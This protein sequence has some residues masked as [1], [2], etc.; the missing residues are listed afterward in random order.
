MNIANENWN[1]RRPAYREFEFD[2]TSIDSS[3][4]KLVFEISETTGWKICADK[5]PLEVRIHNAAKYDYILLYSCLPLR[6]I[7]IIIY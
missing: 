3:D 4:K 6:G 1:W 2:N 5:E 7:T